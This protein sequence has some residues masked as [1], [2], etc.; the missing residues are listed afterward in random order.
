MGLQTKIAWTNF[1][2]GELDPALEGQFLW[3]SYYAGCRR[4]EN[5]LVQR[6]GG[7]TRRGGT[8][9]VAP[10]GDA[11]HPVI[12]VKF[13]WSAG[14][15]YVLEFGH[16]YLRVFMDRAQVMKNG[17]PY[18]IATPYA[19]EHLAGLKFY[20]SGDVMFITHQQVRPHELNRLAHDDWQL[21]EVS[22]TS[23]PSA[24]KDGEWP[25]AVGMFEQRSVFAG[26]P[27]K[28]I[29]TWFSKAGDPRDFTTGTE[30]DD[31]MEYKIASARQDG[32]VW[33]ADHR[34]LVLATPGGVWYLG[35]RDGLS[36][37]TP[38]KAEIETSYGAAPLQGLVVRKSLIFVTR[39][40][41]RVMEVAYRLDS[42]D[43]GPRDLMLNAGHIA[44]AG[45]KGLDWS[46]SP[47]EV[48]WA[49]LADGSLLAGTY[50]PPEKVL[51]WSRQRTAGYFESV[52]CI[53]GP[54]SDQVWLVVRREI[55]GQSK[56]FVEILEDPDCQAIEDAYFVDCGLS[57]QGEPTDQV[58]GLEHLAGQRVQ[59]LA[60]GAVH[61]ELT[62][63][64][65]GTITLDQPASKVHAGLG[66]TSRLTT[67]RAEPGG[68]GRL[69]QGSLQRMVGCVLRLHRTGAAFQVGPSED[70]LQVL[71]MRTASDL[72]DRPLPLFSGD[73][74]KITF[75]TGHSRQA[76]VCLKQ[77]LPIPMT[78]LAIMA[79]V[80]AND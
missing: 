53:P 54:D 66:Y 37:T 56:R 26:T 10:V 1:T 7:V 11:D 24:W 45:I 73:T 43:L 76:R 34:R 62:V 50:Y 60:D 18:Q 40:Q 35:S 12:L 16:Q 17:A 48:I 22:F 67:M 46:Q 65:D 31:A 27:D 58:G 39:D 64:P 57:Y 42:D 29:T 20:Q 4:L 44:R 52:C 8:R 61:R 70:E 15:C 69:A 55:G 13:V 63:A 51:A 78:V 21:K 68:P 80:E 59:V 74:D 23:M 77:D 36:P 49:V 6:T 33:V 25:G 75:A 47:Q 5:F 19:A 79:E 28:A 14:Q 71:E 72:M 9:L 32:I 30:P 38:P 3:E 2:A 41:R